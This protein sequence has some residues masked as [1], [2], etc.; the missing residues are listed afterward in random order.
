MKTP[1]QIEEYLR[2]HFFA[3]ITEAHKFRNHLMTIFVRKFTIK[4]SHTYPN[5]KTI[6]ETITFDEAIKFLNQ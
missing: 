4:Y 5:G 3:N 2:T 6:N 1:E